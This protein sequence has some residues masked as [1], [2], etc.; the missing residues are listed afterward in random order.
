VAGLAATLG[1]GALTN[2]YQDVLKSK[3]ILITGTNTP[4]TIR[5]SQITFMK[6]SPRTVPNSLSSIQT[7]QTCG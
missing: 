7:D 6:L 2:P 4:P 5:S 1:S 3:V